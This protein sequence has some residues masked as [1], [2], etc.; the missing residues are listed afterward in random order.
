MNK[1][2]VT[3]TLLSGLASTTATKA[4]AEEQRDWQASA[5]LGFSMTSG[6]TDTTSINT[7]I[8]VLQNLEFWEI[9]YKF[10]GI[11]QENEEET[12]ADKKDY[13][14]KGQY[15]LEDTTSFLFVEGKRNED[16][17]GPFAEQNTISVGYG[18]HLYENEDLLIKADIGPGYTSYEF[19]ES[20][21]RDNSS[22]VH[23]AGNLKWQISESADFTQ[24]LIVDQQLS[25]D[26]NRLSVSQSTLGARINGALKMTLD[27]KIT[28]N[29]EVQEDKKKTDTITSVNLVYSF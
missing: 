24:S 26:K 19:N 28:H 27:V 8:Q 12:T 3:L 14:V 29:S 5:G 1:T 18:Q 2:L 4:V 11:K 17:F 7:N 22:I 23:L 13:S 6:N 10:D 16:K 21:I 15:K 20:G 25:D 9:L